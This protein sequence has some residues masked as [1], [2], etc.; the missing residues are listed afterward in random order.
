M[1]AAVE[2]GADYV[3][4]VFFAKS[5]RNLSLDAAAA[6]ATLARGRAKIVA[7]TVDADDAALEEIATT[8]APDYFQL[9]GSETPERVAEIATLFSVPIIKALGV[10]S[11]D[12]V[13]KAQAFTTAD[14]VLFDAKP[15]PDAER[16]GGNGVP[17]DWRL[18]ARAGERPFML[19]G[20]LNAE[21]VEEAI[22]LTKPSAVD[23]SSGVEASPG[24]KD[25]DRIRRFLHAVK[26]AKA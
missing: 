13:A 19:S 26:T 3:G 9:H 23:V 1:D 12:D 11:P 24:V 4:L 17:F 21:N 8:V 16:P 25:L 2:A 14:L 18:L 7:L 5:P 10:S 6:L 22:R 15:L 20:G